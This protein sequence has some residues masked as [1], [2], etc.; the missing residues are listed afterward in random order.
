MGGF[1]V[2]AHQERFVAV[3][4]LYPVDGFFRNEVG[5]ETEYTFSETSV[6]RPWVGT[7]DESGV[8]VLSLVLENGIVIK[9]LW[10]R[11]DV[12]FPDKPCAVSV[13]L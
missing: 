12:P 5:R 8:T 7:F 1:E 11:L 2:A 9:S 3:L 4:L 10:L 6:A 13:C